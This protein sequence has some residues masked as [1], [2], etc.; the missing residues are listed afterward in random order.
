VCQILETSWKYLGKPLESVWNYK[1]WRVLGAWYKRLSPPAKFLTIF[2][3]R[4]LKHPLSENGQEF[5]NY[6][7]NT[8]RRGQTE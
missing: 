7:K 1:L 8:K 6:E 2:A 4:G 3:Q 5:C